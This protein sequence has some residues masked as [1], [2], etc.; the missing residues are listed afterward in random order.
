MKKSYKLD[1]VDCPNCAAKLESK[2]AKI[3]GVEKISVNF[4]TQK[5]TLTASDEKFE[6]VLEAVHEKQ[7]ELEPDWVLEIK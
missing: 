6:S 4:L 7:K 2:L 5:L 3:E 1:G